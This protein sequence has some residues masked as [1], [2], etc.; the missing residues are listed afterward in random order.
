[1]FF[2]FAKTLHSF[3]LHLTFYIYLYFFLMMV[4]GRILFPHAEKV[5]AELFIEVV[6]L[7]PLMCN[8]SS[9]RTQVFYMDGFLCGLVILFH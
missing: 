2:F 4:L 8:D 1:M 5:V 9:V 3:L 6:I 7:S